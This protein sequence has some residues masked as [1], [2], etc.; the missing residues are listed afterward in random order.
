M[1]YPSHCGGDAM[2]PMN[3]TETVGAKCKATITHRRFV[4]NRPSPGP[5]L[6]HLGRRLLPLDDGH[7]KQP[8]GIQCPALLLHAIVSVVE[9]AVPHARTRHPPHLRRGRL[10]APR[11]FRRDHT[12]SK[13][14][15][16][17]SCLRKA[18]FPTPCLKHNRKPH[19]SRPLRLS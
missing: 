14:L 2:A 19:R 8:P 12:L 9:E 10:H 17:T 4:I 11:I 6:H 5:Y 7:E 1:L 18:L 13:D 16:P 3:A 15:F